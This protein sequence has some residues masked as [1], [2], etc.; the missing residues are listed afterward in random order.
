[1]DDSRMIELLFERNEAA[2][3]E[4]ERKYGAA[5]YSVARNILGNDADAE[6]CVNDSYLG[7][8]NSIPPHRPR[9]LL[10]YVCRIVRNLAIKKYHQNTA[11]KRNSL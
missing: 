4:L 6:E 8:W 1:M 11:Q 2:L 7:V 5:C 10:P 9:Q 3:A